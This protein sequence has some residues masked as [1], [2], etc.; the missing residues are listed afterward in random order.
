MGSIRIT[1]LIVCA[2]L[3]LV[4]GLPGPADGTDA[5]PPFEAAAP[6]VLA[7]AANP[8]VVDPGSTEAEEDAED[9]EDTGNWDT[10]PDSTSEWQPLDQLQNP[11]RGIPLPSDST[12]TPPPTGIILPSNGA[13]SDTLR[14]VQP[15]TP[16][17]GATPGKTG[18]I[19]PQRPASAPSER[20]GVLG[21]SP[22]AIVA[23]LA[24][25]HVF[26]VRAATN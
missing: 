19:G 25:L 3:A 7:Q 23:G 1:C 26:I 20:N 16:G 13:P 18:G 8:P 15:A 11:K 21:I 17:A 5:S 10:A 9:P 4:T 14:A 2:A 6:V 24:V 12:A 22:V